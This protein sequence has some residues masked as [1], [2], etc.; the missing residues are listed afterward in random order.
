MDDVKPMRL[1]AYYYGFDATGAEAID[2]VLSAV[3]CA[4]KAYH[5]T[6]DW[7]NECDPYEPFLRGET[8]VAWIQNAAVEAATALTA[9]QARIRE[10]EAEVARVRS[11]REYIIGF[12]AGWDEA[13][14]QTLLF[15]TMLRK[16]WSGDEVQKWID[17]RMDELRARAL[18]EAS[19]D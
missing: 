10:L 5:L 14:E 17:Q 19:H 13:A 18:T 11:D 3:A 4:G 2:R 12:N 15:P 8:P 9:A 16:M 1:D 7:S 6:E